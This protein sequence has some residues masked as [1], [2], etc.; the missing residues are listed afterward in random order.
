MADC[1]RLFVHY[2]AARDSI[3]GALPGRRQRA[4]GPCSGLRGGDAGQCEQVPP[5]APAYPH[6]LQVAEA[7]LGAL[8]ALAIARP[9][10]LVDKRSPA[11]R[12][13]KDALRPVGG[14]R[15]V[16]FA[17]SS[18]I[19]GKGSSQACA[20]LHLARSLL[21]GQRLPIACPDSEHPH[22]TPPHPHPYP[23]RSLPPS[24]SSSRRCRTLIELLRADEETMVAAQQD[25][26]GDAGTGGPAAHCQRRGRPP[27]KGRTRRA[28]P[29]RRP[30]PR[31]TA[32]RAA[33]CRRKT[34]RATR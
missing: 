1:L 33:R 28:A 6:P 34:A 24:C 2:C 9:S 20:A 32:P 21:S 17:L 27:Q 11:N 18:G 29:R 3:K 26:G 25:G 19:V 31:W 15:G 8:G 30:L 10:I 4:Q 13:M 12:I 5:H 16:G 23:L 14:C 7:A 22:A